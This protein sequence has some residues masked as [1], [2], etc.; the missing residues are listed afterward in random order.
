MNH[1]QVAHRATPAIAPSYPR[2]PVDPRE[3]D[4][5]V[6]WTRVW[7]LY[8]HWLAARADRC[9]DQVDRPHVEHDT[10]LHR[11][12][13]AAARRIAPASEADRRIVSSAAR[14]YAGWALS[15]SR[16]RAS[17]VIARFAVEAANDL[18]LRTIIGAT[19]GGVAPPP[20]WWWDGIR[21][22]HTFEPRTDGYSPP[23]RGRDVFRLAGP[24]PLAEIL[25]EAHARE[26]DW[27]IRRTHLWAMDMLRPP[28]RAIQLAAEII[29]RNG[30]PGGEVLAVELGHSVG[31]QALSANLPRARV[32]VANCIFRTGAGARPAGAVVLSLPCIR[33]V[34][35]ALLAAHPD[36]GMD[37]RT[38]DQFEPGRFRHRSSHAEA[39]ACGA[40][41][42]VRPG[43]VLVVLGDVEDG[44]HHEAVAA[45]A[46]TELVPVRLAEGGHTR[47]TVRE[48]IFVWHKGAPWRPHGVLAPTDRLISAWRRL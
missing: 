24:P 31:A 35:H 33:L 34:T 1:T 44:V 41:S 21:Q 46:T 36:S 40:A 43:G 39:V 3:A 45:I 13:D 14:R 16:E 15:H 10:V 7:A 47:D 30:A 19:L 27:T 2:E 18:H 42:W 29:R 38:M 26:P 23:I 28:L 48:P 37:R 17:P 11:E 9:D 22:R 32:R 25:R 8:D 4:Q 6:L 12:I 5:A 20:C